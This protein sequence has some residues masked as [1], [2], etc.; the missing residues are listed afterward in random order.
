VKRISLIGLLLALAL[1]VTPPALADTCDDGLGTTWTV[2]R[3]YSKV[4]GGWDLR[5]IVSGHEDREIWVTRDANMD[6]DPVVAIDPMSGKPAVFWSRQVGLEYRIYTSVFQGGSFGEPKAVTIGGQ[7]FSDRQPYVQYDSFGQCHLVWFR[8]RTDGS[9]VALYS[10]RTG[11]IWSIA[12]QISLLPDQVIGTVIIDVTE[13]E[14]GTLSATY[15]YYRPGS[16][17][18]ESRAVCR[19]GDTSPWRACH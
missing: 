3:E 18:I 19:G 2:V 14:R 8:E 15:Q 9:G 4:T 11:H 6:Q 5:L 16:G 1:M 7:G 13:V 17:T 12:E 10:C